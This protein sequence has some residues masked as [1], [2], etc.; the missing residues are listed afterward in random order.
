MSSILP[1]S[2]VLPVIVVLNG[3]APTEVNALIDILYSTYSC[4]LSSCK[5][6]IA[7]DH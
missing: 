4:K 2:E 3:P 5:Q 1:S 6:N 7:V